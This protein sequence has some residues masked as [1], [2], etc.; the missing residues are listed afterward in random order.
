MENS[1]HIVDS[2]TTDGQNQSQY[3]STDHRDSSYNI[4]S[5]ISSTTLHLAS[6]SSG[7]FSPTNPG[8]DAYN[9]LTIKYHHSQDVNSEKSSST[10]SKRKKGRRTNLE[11]L[12]SLSGPSSQITDYFRSD[13]PTSPTGNSPPA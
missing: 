12:D 10:T 8:S 1:V 4:P 5:N 11:Q 2:P 3:L 6:L 7:R 13:T 9:Q